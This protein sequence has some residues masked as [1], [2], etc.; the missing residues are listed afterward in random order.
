MHLIFLWYHCLVFFHTTYMPLLCSVVTFSI[1]SYH[2]YATC[3]VLFTC[4][5]FFPTTYMPLSCHTITTEYSFIPLICP[6]PVPLS[7]LSI[8]T[9][10][11]YA[12]VLPS[13]I[14]MLLFCLIH[15]LS[16]LSYFHTTYM[17]LFWLTEHLFISLI[18]LCF[19]PFL[20]LL[21]YT[22]N[23]VCIHSFFSVSDY[24]VYIFPSHNCFW[25][26]LWLLCPHLVHCSWLV[27]AEHILFV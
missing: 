6:C 14:Y 20:L 22:S 3:S 18:C 25:S 15:L 13:E 1:L 11:L 19:D 21:S 16:I 2:F 12:L 23:V 4:S 24:L 8:L 9:Y 27:R 7:P 17:S 5:A 26:V 10:H